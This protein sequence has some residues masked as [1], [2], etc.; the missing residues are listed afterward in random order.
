M[1]RKSLTIPAPKS[2]PSSALISP[3]VL[4][5]RPFSL[6]HWSRVERSSR[7]PLS[8]SSGPKGR[9]RGTDGRT[10]R[11][12]GEW[13]ETKMKGRGP[14]IPLEFKPVSAY[15]LNRSH[16]ARNRCLSVC[17]NYNE[18]L[19]GSAAA[20]HDARSSSNFQTYVTDR[21]TVYRLFI[22]SCLG[23]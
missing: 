19:V 7:P 15:K 13:M 10:D 2:L 20:A 3:N 21:G 16:R 14:A 9:R 23:L 22:L 18:S 1:P 6:S 8:S 4:A 11:W 5:E 17:V 12:I